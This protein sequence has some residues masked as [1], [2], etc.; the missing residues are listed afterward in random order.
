M[1]LNNHSQSRPSPTCAEEL[2]PHQNPPGPN[3][4]PVGIEEW[5][6]WQQE[7]DESVKDYY[8][9]LG[10]SHDVFIPSFTVQIYSSHLSSPVER[11]NNV[12]SGRILWKLL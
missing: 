4:E 2:D 12:R 6:E 9:L 8:A 1:P 7:Q 10:V 11:R 3:A 5:E